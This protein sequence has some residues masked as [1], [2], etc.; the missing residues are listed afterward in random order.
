MIIL[1]KSKFAYDLERKRFCVSDRDNSSPP[2]HTS[3]GEIPMIIRLSLLKKERWD[4]IDWLMK[5]LFIF[6]R[7]TLSERQSTYRKLESSQGTIGK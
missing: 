7:R 4:N 2:I 5:R 6:E 1:Y 3:T